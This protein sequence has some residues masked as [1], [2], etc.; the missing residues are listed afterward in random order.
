LRIVIRRLRSGRAHG[1]RSCIDI[2]RG[3]GIGGGIGP[4]LGFKSFHPFLECSHLQNEVLN[5]LLFREG[6]VLCIA[7]ACDE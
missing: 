3:I 4:L 7:Q 2:G 1:P 6:R 5:Y